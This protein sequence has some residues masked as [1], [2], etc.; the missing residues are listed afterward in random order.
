MFTSQRGPAPAFFRYAPALGA[1]ALLLLGASTIVGLFKDAPLAPVYGL[2]LVFAV[3]FRLAPAPQ[4]PV[5]VGAPFSAGGLHQPAHSR[6][7]GDGESHPRAFVNCPQRRGAETQGRK[8]NA[9]HRDL[10]SLRLRV[11][12]LRSSVSSP[13]PTAATRWPATI[14][15]A[16]Y[17][18]PS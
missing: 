6:R 17:S 12:C 14:R 9:S 15:A 3:L 4:R 10:A 5:H 2:L 13:S 7:G 1:A 8:G 16:R 18:S 11:R